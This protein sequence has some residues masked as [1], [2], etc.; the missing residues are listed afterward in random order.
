M[1]LRDYYEEGKREGEEQL[2]LIGV[3]YRALKWIMW[4]W[5]GLFFAIL[6]IVFGVVTALTI[7]GFPY[8]KEAFVSARLTLL[9]SDRAINAS[10][11]H[12]GF[13]TAPIANI[14]WCFTFG[15][16]MS[17]LYAIIGILMFC[18]LIFIPLGIAYFKMA[19]YSFMPFGTT[20][21]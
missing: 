17:L 8:A 12:S 21:D 2:A 9:D 5:L 14:L 11:I 15:L 7:V 19:K 3:A 20:F 1:S 13:K 16:V 18:T 4:H 6:W 10:K